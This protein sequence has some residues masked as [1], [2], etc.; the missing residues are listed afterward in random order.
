MTRKDLENL[1]YQMQ[2][3]DES[4]AWLKDRIAQVVNKV[5]IVEATQPI[6][7]ELLHSLEHEF[8]VLK[9]KNLIE[10]QISDSLYAKFQSIPQQTGQYKIPS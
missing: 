2:V 1:V 8:H 10:K 6:D 7:Y 3:A 5:A 9:R 4:V